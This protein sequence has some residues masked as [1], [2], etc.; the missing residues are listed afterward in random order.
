MSRVIAILIV[1]IPQI[2]LSQKQTIPIADLFGQNSSPVNSSQFDNHSEGTLKFFHYQNE[3]EAAF[4]TLIKLDLY[5]IGEEI[6]TRQIPNA[7][8]L[9]KKNSKSVVLLLSPDGQSIGAG[10][11][12]SESGY[13]ITN[14][15]V[16]QDAEYM[17]VYFYSPEFSSIEELVDSKFSYAKIEA[18]DETKDLAYLKISDTLKY[19]SLSMAQSNE[20]NIADDVFAIGHPESLL[21]SFSYGVI[22]QIRNNY[23]WEYSDGSSFK[24]KI[25]Q[26]QTPINPGNSGGPLFNTKG[27]LIGINSFT[28]QNSDGLNFA[29]HINEIK[30]FINEVK[31][32]EHHYVYTEPKIDEV[33]YNWDEFDTDKN[34]VIDRWAIDIDGDGYYDYAAIDENEDKVIDYYTMDSNND[35]Y[36][37]V[38]IYDKNSDGQ[39]EYYLMDTDYNRYFDTVGIDDN[40]DNIPDRYYD[41][42]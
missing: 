30:Q 22:S 11:I 13:L 8:K 29:I 23:K 42:P 34:G 24:A 6:T 20:I 1:L 28:S 10:C 37:D 32:G 5:N 35:R 25:I 27:R 21:W 16:V 14:W 9:Y 12:I 18:A 15:H 33:E 40:S 7:S 26:T 17:I 2:I 38:E 39:Y 19:N 31:D 3:K 41:Y 4:D 36:F